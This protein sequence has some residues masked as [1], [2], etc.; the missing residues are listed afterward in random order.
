[1]SIRLDRAKGR[2]S[3]KVDLGRVDITWKF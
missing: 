1:V 2:G 3:T